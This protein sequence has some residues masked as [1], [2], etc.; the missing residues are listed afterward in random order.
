MTTSNPQGKGLVPI[1]E[2]WQST[3]ATQVAAKPSAQVL[4]DYFTSLLVLSAEFHFKPCLGVAY[5]LYWCEPRWKLS[6]IGP[7]EWGDGIPGDYLGCCSLRDDMTWHLQPIDTVSEHVALTDALRRFHEGFCAM[8]DNDAPLEDK[9]PYFVRKLPYYRLLLS[10]GLASSLSKSIALS[11]L[12]SISSR[13]WLQG[14]P[15]AQPLLLGR[16]P[17]A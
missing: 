3:Q 14:L 13:Q 16:S 6:L 10:A 11:S 8:L 7:V 5:H 17:S 15:D 4:S 9:L 1:L 12:H 2:A